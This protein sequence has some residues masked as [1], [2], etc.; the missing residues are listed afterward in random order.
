MPSS[1]S[2]SEPALW[3]RSFCL[4]AGVAAGVVAVVWL[5]VVLVDPFDILPLSPPAN[6]VPVAS[7]ARFAF[8]SLARSTRFDSAIFGTSTSRLLR[9][10]ALNPLFAARFV[11]LSMNDATVHE[12]AQIMAVFRR[13]HPSPAVVMVGLDLRWCGTGDTYLLFTG[14]QFPA[15]MYGE[16]RWQG[17]AEMLNMYAVQSAGQAFGVLAGIKPQ[18]YGS[19][20]YT[21]FVPP[22][23]QYDR[24]KVARKLAEAGPSV[25]P[26]A[27]SGPP[28]FWRYP[29]LETLRDA[30]AAFPP[31]TR[32]VL[33][34]VPYHRTLFPA[35]GSDGALAWA[36]CKRRVATLARSLPNTVAVDFMR[37]SPVTET[38]DNYWDPQHYTVATA[39][40]LARDLKRAA[41]GLVSEDYHLLWPDHEG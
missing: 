28:S 13:A 17:Y 23:S 33:F 3:R 21:R 14:R 16:N 40:R 15:W 9:P 36:E 11:N 1:T 25:P 12:T 30:M 32:K 26:G 39:D 27:R 8:P 38:N 4:A 7:N 29:A 18:D 6:R 22:D 41:D 37:P 34:F 20:G 35:P 19:D 31:D 5:F 24:A 2:S 10:D